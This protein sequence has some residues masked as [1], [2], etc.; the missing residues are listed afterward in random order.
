MSC[1]ADWLKEFILL[2]AL[3]IAF[4]CWS[5]EVVRLQIAFTLL[6][7]CLKYAVSLLFYPESLIILKSTV[8]Y[9]VVAT[10]SRSARR[11]APEGGAALAS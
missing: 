8:S 11:V 4:E 7:Y 6:V 3:C 1:N 5:V 2:W 10:P 9:D